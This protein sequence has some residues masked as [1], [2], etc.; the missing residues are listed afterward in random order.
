[1]TI[2]GASG[3]FEA[4]NR[5]DVRMIQRREQPRLARK[6]RQPIRI[7]REARWQHLDGDVPSELGVARA[8]HLAHPARPERTDNLERTEFRTDGEAHVATCG[9]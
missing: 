5:G 4:V 3:V 1:M 7:A 2:A 6:S 8:I 9:F